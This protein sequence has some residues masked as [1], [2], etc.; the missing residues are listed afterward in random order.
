MI[1][2]AILFVSWECV[3]CVWCVCGV[4]NSRQQHTLRCAK[5]PVFNIWQ[6]NGVL[7]IWILMLA[8]WVFA[9]AR[10]LIVVVA[11]GCTKSDRM[12]KQIRFYDQNYAAEFVLAFWWE[13]FRI[14][15]LHNRQATSAIGIVAAA[16]IHMLCVGR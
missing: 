10:Q 1:I 15:L 5:N 2:I 13:N 9:R 7:Y 8:L 14:A 4:C 11:D 12:R 16:V 3:V 6:I